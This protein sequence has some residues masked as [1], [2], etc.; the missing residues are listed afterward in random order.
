MLSSADNSGAHVSCADYGATAVCCAQPRLSRILRGG[1]A[2]RYRICYYATVPAER[3]LCLVRRMTYR[4][5]RARARTH[6]YLSA[7][8]TGKAFRDSAFIDTTLWKHLLPSC[9]C[10][11]S[12]CRHIYIQLGEVKVVQTYGLRR[13]SILIFVRGVRMD[14]SAW[15]R[16]TLYKVKYSVWK[17]GEPVALSKRRSRNPVKLSTNPPFYRSS[18]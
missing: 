3:T 13:L 7:P 4:P 17:K 2:R 11:Q 14:V 9:H 18:R 15:P 8:N 5:P 6:K 10:H 1:A 12:T 16:F